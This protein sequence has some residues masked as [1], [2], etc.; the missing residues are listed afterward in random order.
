MRTGGELSWAYDFVVPD[1]TDVV[2][3]PSNCSAMWHESDGD[4]AQQGLAG[5]RFYECYNYD[6][7]FLPGKTSQPEFG[8][9][10]T[11]VIAHATG[12]VS[13]NNP[14]RN[15][16]ELEDDNPANDIAEVVINPNGGGGGSLPVTGTQTAAVAGAGAALLVGGAVIFMMARRR[17]VVL[18][19]P[20]DGGAE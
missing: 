14:F 11:E 19:T 4:H 20:K 8:L 12:T 2:N 3:V 5:K 7:L 13:F 18:V 17:R 9:K 15:P 1:G 6:P 16:A 10:I